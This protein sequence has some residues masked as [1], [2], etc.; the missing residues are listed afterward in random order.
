MRID[1]SNGQGYVKH[2]VNDLSE[3]SLEFW[4]RFSNAS[5]AS[6]KI[7]LF[8]EGAPSPDYYACGIEF[9]GSIIKKSDGGE[10]T[11]LEH[12]TSAFSII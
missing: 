7:L 10:W 3:G 1:G 12:G 5:K 4:I 9:Q 2:F 6:V 8:D 11:E